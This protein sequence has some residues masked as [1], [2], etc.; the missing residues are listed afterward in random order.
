MDGIVVVCVH[1]LIL[2]VFI[3]RRS[4][5]KENIHSIPHLKCS[6]F[7]QIHHSQT[8]MSS[9]RSCIMFLLFIVIGFQ[10]CFILDINGQHI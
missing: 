8:G 3:F 5:I 2:F 6:S 9:E 10:L 7:S 1:V 4:F